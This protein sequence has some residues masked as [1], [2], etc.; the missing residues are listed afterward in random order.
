MLAAAGI[1]AAQDGQKGPA[2][3]WPCVAGRAVDPSYLEVSESSGGQIFLFQ[4][5]E[6]AHTSAVMTAGFTHKA[7]ILRAIGQLSG[8]RDFEFPVDT[9]VEGIYVL[10]SLQC[11]NTIQVTRPNGSELTQSNSQLSVDLQAGRI[12]RVDYPEP[13]TWRVRLIGTGLFVLSVLAKTDLGLGQVTFQDGRV[14]ARISGQ[15]SIVKLR[16]LDAS[17]AVSVE[18]PV[19][20]PDEQGLY[21][22]NLVPRSERF[23][24]LLTGTDGTGRPFQRVHPPLLRAHGAK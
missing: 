1:S 17:G 23:R 6:V 5:N 16:L 9:G 8:T 18:S 24:V 20:E 7:T 19:L 4:K 22:A 15:A 10:A 11:R 13:G 3:G 12:L 14:T 21:E 2:P